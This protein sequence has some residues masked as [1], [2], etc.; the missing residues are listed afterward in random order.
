M[1]YVHFR[2]IVMLLDDL[3]DLFVYVVVMFTNIF[4]VI[5]L[6]HASKLFL[7]MHFRNIHL[8]KFILM[9]HFIVVDCHFVE[10]LQVHHL[11]LFDFFE[12]LVLAFD[13]QPY[14]IYRAR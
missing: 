10:H 4:I 1:S 2:W 5:S 12:Q 13:L 9:R 3:F 14:Q 6:I 11:G 7:L 8:F